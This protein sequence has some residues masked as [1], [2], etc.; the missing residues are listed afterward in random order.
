M[1]SDQVAIWK[2]EE[3]ETD[4]NIALSMYRAAAKSSK[5]TEDAKLE[6]IVLMSADTDLV[7][8]LRAI[9]EDFPAILVGTIFP[10]RESGSRPSPG[11]LIEH[12]HW[13][14]RHVSEKELAAY[15]F[16]NKVPTRKKPAIKPDFW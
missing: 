13:T 4:V 6:Q 9:R 10:H 8:A 5:A 11:S 3:K 16:P 1:R 14:R 12:S 15:Q 7:P 2:L